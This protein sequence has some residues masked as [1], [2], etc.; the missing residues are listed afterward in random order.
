MITAIKKG[1]NMKKMLLAGAAGLLMTLPGITKASVLTFESSGSQYMLLFDPQGYGTSQLPSSC[2]YRS[3]DCK[4]G[5]KPTYP[6]IV[7]TPPPP[8]KDNKPVGGNKPSGPSGGNNPPP[9][10]NGPTGPTGPTGGD[11]I[12]PPPDNGGTLPGGNMGGGGC[13]PA[14]V[15]LPDPAAMSGAGLAATALIRWIRAR[16]Q[17]RA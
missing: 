12:P 8:V 2:F 3:Y 10:N 6:T 13:D 4:I 16:R 14:S 11:V 15:P 17:N 9:P 5:S 7:F 1:S